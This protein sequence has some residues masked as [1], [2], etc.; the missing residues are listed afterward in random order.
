MILYALALLP[1]IA[2]LET[3]LDGLIFAIK[4]LQKWFA[5]DSALAGFFE[6]ID[7]WYEKLCLIGPPLDYH[8]ESEKSILITHEKNLLL[9][10]EY[11]KEHKFKIKA[12]HRYLGGYLG[13]TAL[14]EDYVS[15]KVE[16][17][18]DPVN[19]FAEM[20]PH[21]PQATFAGYAHSLQFE[22]AYIQQ[23]IE[24]E[25]RLFD[26]LEKAINKNLLPALFET[27]VIPP[28]L[29]KVTSL[30]CKHG[31]I[32]ALDPCRKTALNRE[33]SK[34]STA[35]L[36]DAILGLNNFKQNIC[37]ATM[38]TGRAGRIGRK[39]EAYKGVR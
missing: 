5:D 37:Q 4:Q 35:H 15:E 36:V 12:R 32:G 2:V 10:S 3:L 26:L 7:E 25:E 34:A 21:Q 16:D 1:V 28:D 8:P 38:E 23:A 20:M 9:A 29:R 31:G 39:E 14:T 22:W 24:V 18:V 27:N 17:W 13:S 6:A 11:F 33:T 19:I 30:P